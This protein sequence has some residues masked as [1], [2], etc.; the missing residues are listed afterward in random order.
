MLNIISFFIDNPIML[1]IAIFI[2]AVMGITLKGDLSSFKPSSG[3]KTPSDLHV[4]KQFLTNRERA[5]YNKLE[6]II[7]GRFKIMCQVRL[8]DVISV[9]PKYRKEK[10]G[11]GYF[12]R[13]SQWH[14]DYVLI[15]EDFNVKCVI[16]LD[17]NSHNRPDRIRRDN[18]FNLALNQA[19]IRL[20]R[21]KNIKELDSETLTL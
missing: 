1:M 8:V 6:R 11:I 13:I 7:N 2:I 18:Y 21:F 4:R 12:R 10:G 5:F 15:D 9:N 14:C 16:E 3:R 17:D 20:M 19:G